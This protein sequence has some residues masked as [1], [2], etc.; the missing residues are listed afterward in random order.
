MGTDPLT[1]TT[2]SLAILNLATP[3]PEPSRHV[4]DRSAPL[5]T[6]LIEVPLAGRCPPL[7]HRRGPSTRHA[8]YQLIYR[9]IN[10]TVPSIN[11]DSAP[12]AR[13]AHA[14]CLGERCAPLTNDDPALVV[15]DA[16]TCGV[17]TW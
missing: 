4:P 14:V 10:T 5:G 3:P 7:P 12:A 9:P 17:A 2:P 1:R 6:A 8:V 11:D 16:H 13:L 15:E